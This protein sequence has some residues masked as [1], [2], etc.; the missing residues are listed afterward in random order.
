MLDTVINLKRFLHSHMCQSEHTSDI[1]V[2]RDEEDALELGTSNVIMPTSGNAKLLWPLLYIYSVY[3]L[4]FNK[5]HSC[6]CAAVELHEFRAFR[7]RFRIWDFSGQGR[8]RHLWK[9]Q[10]VH[11]D[12]CIYVIDA[13]DWNRIGVAKREFDELISHPGLLFLTFVPAIELCRQTYCS[14]VSV[15]YPPHACQQ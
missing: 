2:V 12:A 8:A 6:S 1:N 11:A 7:S 10:C 3:I 13:D 5:I 9:E 15:T 4:Q 14:V